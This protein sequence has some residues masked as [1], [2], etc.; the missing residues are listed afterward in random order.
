MTRI[1][2]NP[3][4]AVTS[5]RANPLPPG[6]PKTRLR[7]LKR[8][9]Y[10]CTWIR[11]DSV[12]GRCPEKATD[13]DHVDPLGGEGDENLRALCGYHHRL[14][15]SSEGGRGVHQAKKK[16]RHPGQIPKDS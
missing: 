3:L 4:R 5:R 8:D 6:W 2:K 14:K 13:V 1:R 12:G 15:S 10:R 7:I 11:Q 16:P 9:G